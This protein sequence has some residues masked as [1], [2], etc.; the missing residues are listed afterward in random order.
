MAE[1]E[2]IVRWLLKSPPKDPEA[3]WKAL[4]KAEGKGTLECVTSACTTPVDPLT[5]T[6]C[7]IFHRALLVSNVRFICQTRISRVISEMVYY[8]NQYSL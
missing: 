3:T 7:S 8:I 4:E 1:E 2:D 6:H 5:L